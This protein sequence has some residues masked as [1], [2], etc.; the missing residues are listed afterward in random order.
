M[1]VLASLDLAAEWSPTTRGLLA[2][3]PREAR[4]G[5]HTLA[6]LRIAGHFDPWSDRLHQHTWLLP[7]ECP[8]MLPP[9]RCAGVY[10]SRGRSG[11]ATADASI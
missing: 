3:I 9:D 10:R 8:R 7:Q 4:H 6:D 5:A 11:S 2:R 1:R